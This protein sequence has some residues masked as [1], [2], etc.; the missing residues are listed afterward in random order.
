MSSPPAPGPIAVNS[1]SARGFTLVELAVVLT[2]IAVLLALVVGTLIRARA[3]ANEASAVSAMKAV[4][5]AQLA[6]LV[7]CGNGSY[8]TTLPRLAT[9]P[10]GRS[11]GYLPE[12]FLAGLTVRRSGYDITLLPGMG[13]KPG[14]LADCNGAPTQTA[15]YVRAVPTS[16]RQT[17]VKAYATNMRTTIFEQEGPTAPAEPFGP[18]AAPVK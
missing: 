14:A 17:G 11:Q 12:E 1:R 5:S 15:Y 13:A 2:I 4:N 6:Y 10:G 8:A 18:P 16:Y 9:P 7:S 3:S